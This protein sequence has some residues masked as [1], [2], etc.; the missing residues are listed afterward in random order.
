MFRLILEMHM[1]ALWLLCC[2]SDCHLNLILMMMVLL[3]MMMMMR[4]PKI[5]H[6]TNIITQF[7]SSFEYFVS[8]I[9]AGAL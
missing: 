5:C 3:V 1:K 2:I 8:K 6:Y 7:E 9:Y 4:G